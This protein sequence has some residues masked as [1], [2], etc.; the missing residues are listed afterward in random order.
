[1]FKSF[2]VSILLCLACNIA[3]ETMGDFYRYYDENGNVVINRSI[4]ADKVKNG[5]EILSSSGRVIEV[6]KR[7][8]TDEELS[9]MT[10]R[11]RRE[12][13]AQTLK[14][15]QREFDLQL[16][17]RYSFV[18]DINAEK[19]RKVKEMDVRVQIL[20]GNLLSVRNE[21]EVAYEKAA[22]IEKAG[23][24]VPENQLK[25]ISS[26]EKKL[27]T[28]EQLMRKLLSDME[29]TRKE[30]LLAIERFKEL[31]SIK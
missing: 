11:Q 4:P 3:A 16:L 27:T 15:E 31:K 12:K 30:Y 29:L 25:H 26:L 8:L 14:S 6:V 7:Q 13:N 18:G 22:K 19:N 9:A 1:M 2:Y 17:R 24:T 21:L 23:R 28:T 20:K 10:D 5:Y